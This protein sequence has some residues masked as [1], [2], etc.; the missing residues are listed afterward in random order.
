MPAPE[1]SALPGGLR[2]DWPVPRQEVLGKRG[3]VLAWI[4][5]QLVRGLVGGVAR[6]PG[7]ARRLLVD[8]LARLARRV[9]RSHSR[10]AEEYLR[11]ALGR[12][13]PPDELARR[14]L[15]AWKHL[16]EVTLDSEVFGARVRP[17]DVR[18]HFEVEL[19]PAAQELLARK[20]GC[21]LISAHIGDWEIGTAV[22]PWLGFDPLYSVSKPPKNRWLSVHAQRLRES[23]GMRLIPRRG[24]MEFIPTIV[25]AGGTVAMMLDQRARVKPVLAPFF[26]RESKCD[27][28]ASVLLRRLRAPIVFAA[29]YRTPGQPFRYRFVAPRV[30]RPEEV[31]GKSA[32][33]VAALVNSELEKLILAAPEQ[34]FWLHDRWR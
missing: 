20:E 30:L 31:A 3:G 8:A 9:D 34:Y 5:C 16:F 28:S 22:M 14:V 10:A 12:D 11:Q 6:L 18:S 13:L 1:T 17:Q 33:E 19:C 15:Q 2:Q 25:R 21:V 7:G 27:R 29:C 26:G 23:R 4:E 32:E 24:A